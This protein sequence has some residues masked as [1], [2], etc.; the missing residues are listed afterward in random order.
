MFRWYK[1]KLLALKGL[2][3]GKVR[4][5]STD[6]EWLPI[7]E[8]SPIIKGLIFLL[9]SLII[10]RIAAWSNTGEPF[11]FI[12]LAFM[13][14]AVS[15]AVIAL[16]IR[17]IWGSNQL[18]LLFWGCVIF[19]FLLNKAT[20]LYYPEFIER[21]EV[22]LPVPVL[23]V[24]AALAPMLTCILISRYSGFIAAF[25]VSLFGNLFI[26]STPG[27]FITSLLTGFAAAYFTQKIRRRS[28]LIMA[29]FRVGLV[30]LICALILGGGLSN[31][32]Q[33]ELILAAVWAI[34]LG[35]LTSFVVGAILPILEWLFDRI[36]DISWL[37]LSDL[38]HPLLKRLSAEAP[39]TY[40]HSLN[41]ANLAEAGADAIEAN[42]TQC[43]ACAYF[44][45]I[46]KLAKPDYFI[47]NLNPD[48]NPHD[49]LSPNM[50]ALVIIAHVKEGV[51]LALKH[52]LRQPI[53]D[54]IREHHGTSMV[55]YFY[56]RAL[57]E[58]EDAR[59]GGKITGMREDDIPE[60]RQE[61]FRYPGPVP[62]S[63]ESAIV[64]LADSIESAS[65]SI[66]NPTAQK[67][68]SLV[69][70]IIDNRVEDGQLEESQLTFNELSI[71]ARQFTSSIKNMLHSRI[72]YPK[73]KKERERRESSIQNH[74]ERP[75]P[76][77][78]QSSEDA[79][80]TA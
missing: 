1:V 36:T 56:R 60:V 11:E 41:V 23:L 6:S 49:N 8:S 18:L 10:Y 39:G 33:G 57:Q 44:H 71:L 58:Q 43:R 14:T 15:V 74:E 24:P 76:A 70:E 61:S 73:E 68:E 20:H 16:A 38:N 31:P 69:K 26:D 34:S 17:E 55:Y 32:G 37:E 67:I 65:R 72:A 22:A 46:G 19:N 54:V 52:H 35:V 9:A 13:V 80:A 53:I 28:D 2:G 50:S 25:L 30:G 29:G 42:A 63:K 75:E 64:S 27:I 4:R 51:N 77:T 48:N 78:G 7:L 5:Q 59:E 12:I 21:A 47:E 62:R 45:D 3:C 66:K 79:Q 40:H